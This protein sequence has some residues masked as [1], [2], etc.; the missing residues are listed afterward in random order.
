MENK[1]PPPR[2]IF[3][4]ECTHVGILGDFSPLAKIFHFRGIASKVNKSA[5]HL[6]SFIAGSPG[7]D[8]VCRPTMSVTPCWKVSRANLP[9]RMSSNLSIMSSTPAAKCFAC[10]LLSVFVFRAE[11]FIFK[12]RSTN[13]HF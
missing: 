9:S 7:S 13:K 11:V 6:R 1:P 5:L 3:R 2:D 10:V 4:Y 8:T 12:K